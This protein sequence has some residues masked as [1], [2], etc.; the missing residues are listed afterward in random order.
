[1]LGPLPSWEAIFERL[2][3]KPLKRGRGPCPFCESS[4]GFSAKNDNGL[5]YCFACGAKGGKIAFVCQFLKCSFK[6]TLAFFGLRPEYKAPSVRQAETR[7]RERSKEAKA[8]L[9]M[10]RQT[11]SNEF[12][13]RSRLETIAKAR[14]ILNPDDEIAW[15]LLQVAYHG[16]PLSELERKLDQ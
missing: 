3:C 8:A 16:V 10:I 14:L 13:L 9:R 2:A 6:E 7:K 15:G 4:T 11:M 1:M 12:K 5:F